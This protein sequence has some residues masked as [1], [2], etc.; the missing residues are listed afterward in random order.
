[1]EKNDEGAQI[2]LSAKRL[3]RQEAKNR[4]ETNGGALLV[5]KKRLKKKKKWLKTNR[6]GT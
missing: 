2:K 6:M 5:L 1:M 3:K 4:N